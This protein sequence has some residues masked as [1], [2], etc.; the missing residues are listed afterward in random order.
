MQALIFMELREDGPAR[1]AFNQALRLSPNNPDVLNNFGWFL[2]LRDDPKRGLEL[3]QR[4][5][6]DTQYSSPEK[7]Y[8]SAGLCLRRMGR[9]EE[10][11]EHLRRAVLIRPDMIGAL[12]NLAG[13][14]FARGP[15]K[16]VQIYLLRYMPPTTT[17]L[18]SRIGGVEIS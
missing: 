7:A 16:D 3:M 13:L 11:G 18:E 1:E 10:A 6:A 4:A 12:F 15:L 17:N 9:N 8:L 14:N 5:A 2:C